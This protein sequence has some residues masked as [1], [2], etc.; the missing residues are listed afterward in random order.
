MPRPPRSGL[1]RHPAASSVA[2]SAEFGSASGHMLKTVVALIS[3]RTS[4]RALAIIPLTGFRITRKHAW[5]LCALYV[6]YMIVSIMQQL[7]LIPHCL[8]LPGDG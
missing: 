3:A 1:I 5:F 6:V 7:S 2:N 4:L 8:P